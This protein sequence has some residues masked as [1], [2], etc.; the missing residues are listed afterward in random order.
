MNHMTP[1]LVNFYRGMGLL[2]KSNEK[3]FSKETEILELESDKESKEE[4]TRAKE[5]TQGAAQGPIRVELVTA[6]E[7]SER[8]PAKKQKVAKASEVARRP[9]ALMA[10][11]DVTLL[12]KTRARPKKKAHRWVIV[13]KSLEGSV[14]MSERI[15]SLAD[16]VNGGSSSIHIWPSKKKQSSS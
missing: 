5:T 12:P 2:T 16:E 7:G 15:A 9:E 8:L 4:D 6:E 14:A 3:R 11:S 10:G 1:F 13:S